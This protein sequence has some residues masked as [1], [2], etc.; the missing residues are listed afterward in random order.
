MPGTM[1]AKQ[2]TNKAQFNH[3]MVGGIAEGMLVTHILNH[4]PHQSSVNL[5]KNM[6]CGPDRY[7][8]AAVL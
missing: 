5:K 3:C 6:P 7:Y 8:P 4:F 2:I 1:N